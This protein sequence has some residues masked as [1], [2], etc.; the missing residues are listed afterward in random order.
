MYSP[1]LPHG[2]PGVQVAISPAIQFPVSLGPVYFNEAVAPDPTLTSTS[3][4][5]GVLFGNLASGSHTITASKAPFAYEALTF[6]VQDRHRALHRLAAARDAGNE[7]FAA[8]SAVVLPLRDKGEYPGFQP[9]GV[10]PW[11]SPESTQAADPSVPEEATEEPHIRS[12]EEEDERG[13]AARGPA[14]S[15]DASDLAGGRRS[16][17][18]GRASPRPPRRIGVTDEGQSV[19]VVVG[20]RAAL[21]GLVVVLDL[22][23]GLSRA[24][25]ADAI[26]GALALLRRAARDALLVAPGLLGGIAPFFGVLALVRRLRSGS[27]R[28]LDVLGIFHACSSCK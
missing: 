27:A 25:T 26:G 8:R 13:R 18:P 24:A 1:D 11:L 20:R 19:S 22:R 3:V 21:V 15:R 4:D 10:E 23:F 12:D 16:D 9:G 2:D 14:G 5:G 28:V 7:R 17:A 6:V